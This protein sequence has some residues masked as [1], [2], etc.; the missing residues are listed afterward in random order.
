ML[1]RNYRLAAGLSQEALAERARMSTHGVGALERGYRRTPQRET[2]ALLASALA[3]NDEQRRSF[4][5]AAM[6]VKV[7]RP[8]SSLSLVPRADT[9]TVDLPL[10]LT[11]FVGRERE[12]NEIAAHVRDHRMVTLTGAGGVGK[13]QTALR[14]ATALREGDDATISFVGFAGISDP[15]LVVTAIASALGMQEV[16]GHPLLATLVSYLKNRALVLILDNCEHVIAE[17][18]LAA[19]T[20]LSDCP[21]LHILATSREPLR[22]GGEY[23]YRLPSLRVP[24]PEAAP[25]LRATDAADY[26]AIVL[27]TDRARAADYRFR[28][29]DENAPIVAELCRRLDGIPLAIELAAARVN[30]LSVKA[31]AEKLDDR[32]RL[33]TRGERTAL[34]RQQTM[35]AAIDWSY[36]LLAAQEQRVFERFSVFVGGCTLDAAAAVCEGQE[37]AGQEVFHLLSSLL[38]KSLLVVDLEASEPRYQLLQSFRQYAHE[39]LRE[40]AYERVEETD[41]VADVQ[42]RHATHMLDFAEYAGRQLSGAAQGAWLERLEREYQNIRAALEWASRSN[43]PAFGC[44]FVASIW[45]FWWLHGYFTEGLT[46]VSCFLDAIKAAPGVVTDEIYGKVLRARVVLLS[47]LGNFDEAYQSCELAIELQRRIEDDAGLAASLTS[48]GI[49]LQFRGDID[50]AEHVQQEGLDIRRRGGDETGV[51]TSLSNLASIAFCKNDLARA[52]ALGEESVAIYR[53]F[54]HESGLA[55]ALMKLGLVAAAE[56]NYERA[57]Q[58]FGECLRMQ[59]AVGDVGSTHYSLANLGRC[60]H[61]RGDYDLA[62]KR[63]HEALDLLDLMANKAAL[64]NVLEHLAATI[65]AVGDPSLGARLLG[66]ADAMRQTIHSPVFPVERVDHEAEVAEVRAM[67]G[68]AAFDVQWCIGASNVQERVLEEARATRLGSVARD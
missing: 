1:L 63:Y 18:A 13:T 32:F 9:T 45:R 22:A 29:T 59:R 4:E 6:R 58:I 2:L 34:P 68:P 60:A 25:E 23:R 36:N 15:S 10:A 49:I 11:R 55:H 26:E 53:R 31:I 37:V 38:D 16:A 65:A 66:A 35:R 24:S 28:L 40:Y 48:M 47:A 20:L 41:K 67:L 62:L 33:L 3:L 5:V 64:A 39:K 14:V 52:A 17:A 21:G 56:Q 8:G 19:A 27:F 61:R 7:T 44:R 43:E 50:R 30:L 57:E 46:W 54:G 12:L 42:R 51:A